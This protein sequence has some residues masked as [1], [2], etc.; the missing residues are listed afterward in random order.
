MQPFRFYAGVFLIAASNLMLQLIQTRILSVVLWYYLAFLIIGMAMFGMT[1][2]AVWVYLRRDRF[3]ERN[4]AGDLSYFSAALA[5][6]TALCAV[7]Q[8]ILPLGTS[9]L[10]GILAGIELAVCVGLPF[11]LSGIVLSLA[12]TRSPFPVSRVYGADLAG[13][14]TG[15]L[16]VLALLNRTSAPDALLW[17]AALS[18]FAALCFGGASDRSR[19]ARPFAAVLSRTGVVFVVLLV[20]AAA[21]GATGVFRPLFVK[22]NAEVGWRTP[23]FSRWNSFAR[24]TVHDNSVQPAQMWGPSPKFQPDA[25][26]IAQRYMTIDGLAGTT[27]YGFDGDLARVGFLKDDV[28]NLAHF[29]P[30]HRRAAVIGIGGGRDMLS[31]RAFGVPDVTGVELN[32]ILSRLL[33]TE[34]GFSD[35]SGLNKLDGLHFETDEARSW[36]ARSRDR[37]DI[38]QMSLVDT[39]A[40]TGAG[41]FTLSENGL[42]T[43]EAWKI[44]LDHLTPNG[45]FTVSRWY[46]PGQ[47]DETGRMISLVMAALYDLGATN[48]RQH[49][50]LVGSGNVGTLIVSRQPFAAENVALLKKISA[51]KDYRILLAPGDTAANP[52]LER[53]AASPDAASLLR[54]TSALS[55]DLT[56][57]TDERP[58]FFDQLPLSHPLRMLALLQRN[59]TEGIAHGN[60]VAAGVLLLMNLT[61][62]LL[63]AITIILPLRPAIRD[64]GRRLA[65]AGTTYFALLGLGFM[66]AEIGMLQRLSVFLGSPIY[67]LSIVLFSLI[68]ATGAGS[69]ISGRL[70]LDARRPFVLWAALTGIYLIA[71]PLWLPV[72]LYAFMSGPLLL[73]ASLCVA[74]T[75]PAGILMGFGFPTGMRLVAAIDRR[76]TPWFWGINGAAGVFASSAAVALSAAFGIHITLVCGGLCYLLLIPAGLAIGWKPGGIATA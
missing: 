68:L 35:F 55:L 4:L 19:T 38:I 72:A 46:A 69:L 36:F 73:R 66:F 48:P 61:S 32:P 64:A 28:I 10:L 43:A 8:M 26:P 2:G 14:A 34:P 65:V 51:D 42:Y 9:G 18:A 22:G 31:A 56:P 3:V 44:F 41:A 1:A 67:A 75:A 50:F 62:L 40:A 76:P 7:L 5:L 23:I 12:L 30:G 71:L 52:V 60:I 45:V 24:I 63:V 20:C 58:F 11:F 39:W 27:T 74:V 54:V 33:T 21:A 13:A 47:V 70:P 17:V 57:S 29:L 16:G 37:F 6:A 25:W 59:P 49:V 15:C 53:I